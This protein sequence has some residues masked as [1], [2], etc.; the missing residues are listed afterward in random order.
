MIKT[1]LKRNNVHESV[2]EQQLWTEKILLSIY[3]I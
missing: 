1:E 3:I 2:N